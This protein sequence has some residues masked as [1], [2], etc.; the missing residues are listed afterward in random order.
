MQQTSALYQRLLSSD[1]HWFE[2]KVVIEVAG[3]F[4]ET[5]LFSVFT[6]HQMFHGSPTIGSAVAGEIQIKMVYPTTVTIPTMAAIRPFVRASGRVRVPSDVTVIDG[7]VTF[8]NG[9][10][11]V[12]DIL[13]LDE[14]IAQILPNDYLGFVTDQYEDAT[15]EWLPQGVYFVDTRERTVTDTG[16]SVLEIHGYDA[17]LKAEQDFQSNTITGDS[18]DV[19]MVDEIASIMGVAVD[20]RTYDIMTAAYTIPLPTGYSCREVLGYIAA[21]YVGAFIMTDEGKLRLVSILELPPESNYLIDE[22]GDAI[23]FGGDRILV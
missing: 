18:T 14:S 13:E 21:M 2:T 20:E 8:Q 6:S 11:F 12:N 15:S 4:G 22:A 7:I 16:E 9:A 23:T 5:D 3:T 17:M 1:N 19:Q 10:A